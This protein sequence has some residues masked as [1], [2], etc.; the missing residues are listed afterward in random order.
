MWISISK[1]IEP[2]FAAKLT[3][4]ATDRRIFRRRFV[5]GF[6]GWFF[7]IAVSCLPFLKPTCRPSA[8][9]IAL[10]QSR[11]L[12]SPA[13]R[14]AC[15][16]QACLRSVRHPRAR[17]FSL[18]PRALPAARRVSRL[19]PGRRSAL[20]DVRSGESEAAGDDRGFSGCRRIDLRAD[21]ASDGAAAR[22]PDLARRVVPGGFPGDA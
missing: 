10:H 1:P 21:A 22:Q 16:V 11:Q 7:L 8:H 18:H 6:R 13:R 15:A 12:P 9:A 14:K 19:A 17:G 4:K 20:R 2:E 3:R 5:P